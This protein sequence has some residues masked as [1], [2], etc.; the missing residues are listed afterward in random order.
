[1]HI[2]Q[3]MGAEAFLEQMMQNGSDASRQRRAAL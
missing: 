3:N 1:M 2:K